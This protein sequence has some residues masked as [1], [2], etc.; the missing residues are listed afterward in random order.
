MCMRALLID[1]RYILRARLRRPHAVLIEAGTLT[2][3]LVLISLTIGVLHAILQRPPVTDSDRLVGV[4]A[5]VESRVLDFDEIAYPDYLEYASQ[6][7]LFAETIAIGQLGT[8]LSSED[9]RGGTVAGQTFSG[10]FFERLGTQTIYGRLPR[11]AD[12]DAGEILL[13]HNA[14]RRIFDS[15]TEILGR[16]VRL[17]AS[18]YTIVGVAEPRFPVCSAGSFR[19]SGS[20]WRTMPAGPL[21][22]GASSTIAAAAP[23]GRSRG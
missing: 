20:R 23:S 8:V 13:S 10:P 17:G 2:V 7:Q 22:T 9:G 19:T 12:A 3:G 14:W 5:A 15:D 4:T 6:S 21:I 16:S 18:A 1:L 11:A